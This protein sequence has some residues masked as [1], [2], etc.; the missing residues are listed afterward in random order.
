MPMTIREAERRLSKA[1]YREV[2]G[3]KGSHRKFVN[4]NAEIQTVIITSHGKEISRK[5]ERDVRKATGK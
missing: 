4:D 5:V 1:G 2:S 3:G